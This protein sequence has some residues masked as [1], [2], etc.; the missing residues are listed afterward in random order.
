MDGSGFK[1]FN[2]L[3]K[4]GKFKNIF[5]SKNVLEKD[6][7][8]KSNKKEEDK[9]E[10]RTER[11]KG[12]AVMCNGDGVEKKDKHGNRKKESKTDKKYR[13]EEEKDPRILPM[14][15]AAP[16][17]KHDGSTKQRNFSENKNV[18]TPPEK[19]QKN[20]SMIPPQ[21]SPN[22]SPAV[23]PAAPIM[24]QHLHPQVTQQTQI[25]RG[26]SG[27]MVIPKKT[28]ISEIPRNILEKIA[29][30]FTNNSISISIKGLKLAFE[31][32]F[33]DSYIPP[34]E[35]SPTFNLPENADKNRNK[36]I[37]CIEA[38][39]VVLKDNITPGNYIHANYINSSISRQ[40]LIITQAP[41]TTT[42]VNFW[43][44]IWQE[45]CEYIVMLCD[46]SDN[47][48]R[49]CSEYFPKPGSESKF[50]PFTILNKGS[51]I[52][53]CNTSLIITQLSLR[54]ND[55]DL[56][57]CHIQWKNLPENGCPPPWEATVPIIYDIVK[58]STKPI[59]IHC[60]SGVRRSG[61]VGAIFIC[62]D[63]FYKGILPKD[64]ITTIKNMRSERAFAVRTPAEYLFIHLQ[65]IQF[66]INSN[67]ITNSQRLMEFFD[68]Y[69]PEHR[70]Q[71]K[72]EKDIECVSAFGMCAASPK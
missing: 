42:I 36:G 49:I 61:Y 2:P 65:L 1:K 24:T 64:L 62:L 40:R 18:V 19:R 9:D 56:S 57:I 3:Q 7:D 13:I 43:R 28:K 68:E 32:E 39:R 10:E 4:L 33:P 41:M 48:K 27:Q 55:K 29:D 58:T 20:P 59:V 47:P 66:M 37:P 6:K 25:P 60:T 45:Q 67:Y 8:R 44:M 11:K 14:I 51:E 15:I 38:S 46:F 35:L 63:D 31:T 70:K 52:H 16:N 71:N 21:P 54:Y 12:Y 50:G 23:S 22:A 26:M 30:D 5:Q 17:N 34:P 69:D 72:K 53:S